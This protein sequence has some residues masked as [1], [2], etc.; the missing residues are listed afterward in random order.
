[1]N[2]SNAGGASS[3]GPVTVKVYASADGVVDAG[4]T[5]LTQVSK[6]LKLAAKKAKA[7]ALKFTVPSVGD[8]TFNIL[9]EV[10]GGGDASASNNVVA[11]TPVT[12]SVPKVDATIGLGIVPTLTSGKKASIA[13]SVINAGGAP[14]AA[15]ATVTLFATT[16]GTLNGQEV[17]LVTTTT[18]LNVKAGKAKNTKLKFTVPAELAGQSR[19]LL[20]KVELA[21]D[22]NA[23][24]DTSTESLTIG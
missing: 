17:Q 10:S 12:F 23:A 4:D 5:L 24:N 6:S 9:T 2:V 3:S 14:I 19:T 16:D 15:P 11:A 22:V 7:L 21:G 20:A 1:V 13:L 8:G 18:T